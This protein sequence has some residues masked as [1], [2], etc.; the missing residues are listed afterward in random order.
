MKQHIPTSATPLPF[1]PKSLDTGSPATDPTFLIKPMTQ[2]D[3]DRLGFE[4]F[5]HNV[6][7][8][9]QDTFRATLIEEVF[10]LY[11]DVEGEEKANLLDEYWQGEDLINM[12]IGDWQA[13][14]QE[15]LWDQSRGAPRRDPEPPPVRTVSIRRRSAASLFAE[16]VKNR[17]MK[18]RDLT[19]EMQSYEPRQRDGITRLVIEGW[20]GLE[21]KFAKTDGI[22]PKDVFEALRREIGKEALA[23]IHTFIMSLGNIGETEAGNSDLPLENES[24]QTGSQEQSGAS[25]SSDGPSTSGAATNN[26][27]SPGSPTHGSESAEIT[28][29][30]SISTS[31]ASGKTP[32]SELSP[33]EEV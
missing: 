14:E 19:I 17:S 18:I 5:R 28:G 32:S 8:V 27:T 15:R 25:A 6:S 21:T 24:D 11:G 12:Q 23:E 33:T 3:F 10:N 26:S 29:S 1:T 22:V 2:E 30:S 16:E 13:R 20:S 7:P 4:L 9:T 31:D